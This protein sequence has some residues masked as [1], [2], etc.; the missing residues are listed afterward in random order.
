MEGA[1]KTR[2]QQAIAA[3][4]QFR[5]ELAEHGLEGQFVERIDTADRELQQLQSEIEAT[6]ETGAA[7]FYYEVV[8]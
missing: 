4:D 1:Q 8:T 2:V 7:A 5:E 3:L 6:R